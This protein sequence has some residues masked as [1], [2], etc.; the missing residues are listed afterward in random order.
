[1][2]PLR[3]QKD[4]SKKDVQCVYQVQYK[5]CMWDNDDWWL[6][7]NFTETVVMNS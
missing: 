1:M 4:N 3:Q 7:A 2:Y 5:N 6:D